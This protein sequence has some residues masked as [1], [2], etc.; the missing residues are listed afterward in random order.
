M[1]KIFLL[2]LLI[3]AAAP[4]GAEEKCVQIRGRAVQYR[5]NAFFEIWHVGTNHRYFIVDGHSQDLVCKYFDCESPDRQ[6]ALF[7]DFTLCPTEPFKQDAA[8]PATVKNV[9]H[10]RV[11]ATWPPPASPREFVNEFYKW[12]G[13]RVA[14]DMP[15][16]NTLKLMRWDL[17]PELAEKLKEDRK[18]QSMCTEIVGLDFD[19]IVGSQDPADSYEAGEITQTGARYRANIYGTTNG[20]RATKPDVIAEFVHEGD[21]WIFQNFLYPTAKADLLAI[22]RS[23][24]PACTAQQKGTK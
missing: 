14:R 17:S 23:P 2:L 4:I 21:R 11:V 5:G 20:V 12:Y 22:L 15:D 9:A 24:R 13:Q 19:P 3:A 1:Q 7:A 10:P 18:A 8:Q 6:P 16:K